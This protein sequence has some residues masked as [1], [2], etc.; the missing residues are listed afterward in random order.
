MVYRLICKS[1]NCLFETVISIIVVLKEHLTNA[2]SIQLNLS[3]FTEVFL[4]ISNYLNWVPCSNHG[5]NLLGIC[6]F[7]F[8]VSHD[9]WK[10]QKCGNHSTLSVISE[11]THCCMYWCAI[12][13]L[14]RVKGSKIAYKSNVNKWQNRITFWYATIFPS[15]SIVG[16]VAQTL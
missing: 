14:F 5:N 3:M 13:C 11:V 6:V 10:I 15:Q 16:K 12:I 7:S 4:I 2:W 9:A 8:K 1:F